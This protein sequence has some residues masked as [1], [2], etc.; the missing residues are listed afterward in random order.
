MTLAKGR[1]WGHWQRTREAQA[2]LIV[3]RSSL[4]P[5]GAALGR[6]P[7]RKCFWRDAGDLLCLDAKLW[8]LKNT[9]VSSN[10]SF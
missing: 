7:S 8:R 10:Q 9:R 5:L 6:G 4:S 2:S 3:E 1:S